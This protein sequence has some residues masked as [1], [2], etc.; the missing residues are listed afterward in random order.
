MLP[1]L[2][3]ICCS[4]KLIS[5]AEYPCQGPG[6]ASACRCDAEEGGEKE[7]DPTIF[8][9]PARF[10]DSGQQ[11]IVR[12]LTQHMSRDAEISKKT[13]WAAGQKATVM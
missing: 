2:L 7:P 5:F 6:V 11:T 13:F 10:G 3:E 9:L 4:A 12:H 1:P 8:P